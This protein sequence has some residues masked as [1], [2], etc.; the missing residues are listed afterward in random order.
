[1]KGTVQAGRGETG[2]GAARVSAKGGVGPRWA[3]VE[4][5]RRRLAEGYYENPLLLD[6][7]VE[8][9][10]RS[11]LGQPARAGRAPGRK[12]EGRRTRRRHSAA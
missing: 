5:A 3:L 12:E 6:L 9:L 11:I 2:R 7:A 10:V 4:R 1:M 8:K